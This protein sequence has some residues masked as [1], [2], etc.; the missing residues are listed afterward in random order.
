MRKHQVGLRAR[1]LDR[2]DGRK[3]RALPTQVRQFGDRRVQALHQSL[4]RTVPSVPDPTRKAQP[5]RFT[6]TPCSIPDTLDPARDAQPAG[7][8]LAH[9][10]VPLLELDDRLVDRQAGSGRSMD[11]GHRPVP[12]GAQHI[13]H[14]HRLDHANFLAGLDLVALFDRQ[15]DQ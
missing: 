1:G 9:P 7:H 4:Y 8:H 3:S 13:L 15:R 5:G 2:G 10:H 14:L 12:L 6:D 11:L